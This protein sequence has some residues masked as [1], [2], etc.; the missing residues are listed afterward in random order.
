MSSIGK[1]R[2]LLQILEYLQSGRRYHTGQLAEFLGVSK[3]TVFRDLK[4]LQ[5][6]GVQLL[7]D[8]TEQGYWIPTTTYIPPTDLTFEEIL[9]LLLLG[10]N[11]GNPE[12]GIPFQAAGRN[13]AL[14]LLSNLPTSIRTRISG[15]MD[16]MCIRIEPQNP[17]HHDQGHYERVLQ[18]IGER[19]QI[20]LM[21]DCPFGQ[22]QITTLVSPYGVLYQERFWYVI[23]RSSLHR[24]TQT[25][26]VGRILTSA[27]TSDTYEIPP[28]FSLNRHMVKRVG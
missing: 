18:A 17:Q 16:R 1:V 2:R 27:L 7:Y 8:D 15:I 11:L 12:H 24:N 9:S 25:F 13:A 28:R 21:Y 10:E 4:V 5:D 26:H 3:R 14:K 6:S 19:R 22:N 20:R 23:G